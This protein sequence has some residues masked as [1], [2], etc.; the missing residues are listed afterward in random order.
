MTQNSVFVRMWKESTSLKK[1]VHVRTASRMDGFHR[2]VTKNEA[3]YVD[4]NQLLIIPFIIPTLYPVQNKQFWNRLYLRL[5]TTTESLQQHFL[6]LILYRGSGIS[7]L[8][9]GIVLQ[10]LVSDCFCAWVRLVKV[11]RLPGYLTS[12]YVFEITI[13][14]IYFEV[15]IVS[16]CISCLV[17]TDVAIPRRWLFFVLLLYDYLSSRWYVHCLPSECYN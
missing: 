3:G 8:L 7:C 2:C 16:E 5:R 17:E 13:N 10:S 15:R 6:N 1:S 11:A 4:K 14:K 12:A 9:F